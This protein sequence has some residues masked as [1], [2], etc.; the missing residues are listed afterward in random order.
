LPVSY[1]LRW[2]ACVRRCGG[3]QGFLGDCG[4][5]ARCSLRVVCAAASAMGAAWV[6]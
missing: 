4:W 5:A 2:E 6:G 1:G 3:T